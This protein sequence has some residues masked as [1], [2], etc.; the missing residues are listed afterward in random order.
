M[1]DKQPL[2]KN[3]LKLIEYLSQSGNEDE[4]NK[5]LPPRI[6][7]KIYDTNKENRKK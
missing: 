2:K 1:N 3:Q 7:E 4:L 5:I 6:K